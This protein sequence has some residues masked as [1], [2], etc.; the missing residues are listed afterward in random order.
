MFHTPYGDIQATLIINFP[1][2]IGTCISSIVRSKRKCFKNKHKS[3]KKK[4]KENYIY[5][6]NTM[7]LE[8]VF[9]TCRYYTTVKRKFKKIEVKEKKII[10]N[11]SR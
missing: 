3:K 1:S 11:V 10:K 8:N 7:F 4:K 2:S 6:S 5:I 9:V